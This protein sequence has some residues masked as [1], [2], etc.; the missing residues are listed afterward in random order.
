MRMARWFASGAALALAGLLSSGAVALAQGAEARGA[1]AGAYLAARQADTRGDVDAAARYFT[2]ALQDDPDNIALLEAATVSLVSA[3]R[4]PEA[5]PRA[6]SLAALEPA[7]RMAALIRVTQAV[8]S[9]DFD[10]ARALLVASPDAF[11]PLMLKLLEGWS[12]YGA[13]DGAAARAAFAAVGDRP[14]LRLFGQYHLGL[15]LMLDGDAQGA[16]AAFEA[17]GAEVTAPTTRLSLA[18]GVAL[19]A[20]GRPEEATAIYEAALTAARFG[21]PVMEAALARLALGE[22]PQPV[23]Q[24]AAEGAAE[25]LFGL[26]GA[27]VGESGGRVAL[28]HARL[29]THLRPSLT[30]AQ[31]L[32]AELMDADDQAELALAAYAA[33]PGDDPLWGRAQ[34]RRAAVLERIERGDAAA[35]ALRALVARDPASAEAHIALADLLRRREAYEE[36]AASYTKAIE[37]VEAAGRA[38]WTLPYQRGIAYERAGQWDAAEADFKHALTL[39]PDQPLVLNYL[40]YSWVDMGRNLDEAKAMIRTA[41]DMRPDDGYITDSLGWAYYRLGDFEAA[42]EWLEK[43]VALTPVDPVINDHLG[44]ALWRVGRRLEAE[45]QWKRARSFDPDPKDLARIKRKLAVGLDAVLEEEAS[46]APRETTGRD[47]G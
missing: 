41:V 2:R 47:G 15:M 34:I 3:G 28:V 37:I 10:G 6:E 7:H 43:A 25:A 29:A 22:P 12:A 46:V 27:L 44:D 40:G 20:L 32:I 30:P 1:Q 35:E 4:I 14:V 16:L 19:E 24:T 42:V 9:G 31:L 26:A 39:S 36:S 38:D 23:V 18:H 8:Q 13:G 21:D 5:V 17:A 45:F 33:I 11:H